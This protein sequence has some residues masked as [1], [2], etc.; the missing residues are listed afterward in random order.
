[1]QKRQ[2]RF[3]LLIDKVPYRIK[4][5]PFDFNGETRFKVS[6]NEGPEHIFTWDSELKRLTGIDSDASTIPD[7]VEVAIAERLQS[8]RF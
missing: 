1:M 2:H 5:T 8:G 3:E 4:A 6:L 7:N